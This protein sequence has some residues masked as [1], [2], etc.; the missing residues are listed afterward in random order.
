MHH[1]ASEKS[2][3]KCPAL[4]ISFSLT[5]HFHLLIGLAVI[6]Q[7]LS[8]KMSTLDEITEKEIQTRLEDAFEKIINDTVASNS[9]FAKYADRPFVILDYILPRILAISRQV[10]KLYK[11]YLKSNFMEKLL[12]EDDFDKLVMIE[13]YLRMYMNRFHR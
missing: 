6:F 7:Q 4:L 12:E 3:E 5:F 2:I 8:N 10:N 9:Y 13:E 1:F 11:F